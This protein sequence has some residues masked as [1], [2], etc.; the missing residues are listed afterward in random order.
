MQLRQWRSSSED[1]CG[2]VRYATCD[3]TADAWLTTGSSDTELYRMQQNAV[4]LRLGC[5]CGES[6]GAAGAQAIGGLDE[7]P[8]AP[9]RLFFRASSSARR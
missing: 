5:R 8:T 6:C 4:L 1:A 9:R 3:S 2:K 7:G